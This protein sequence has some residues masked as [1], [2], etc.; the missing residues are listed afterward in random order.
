MGGGEGQ[1]GNLPEVVPGLDGVDHSP[2]HDQV[3][4]PAA[5]KVHAAPRPPLLQHLLPCSA[6]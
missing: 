4:E 1:E 6:R 5:H 3:H 2:V